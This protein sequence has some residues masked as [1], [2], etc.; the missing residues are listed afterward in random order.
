ME[1]T[2]YVVARAPG[3]ARTALL[4]SQGTTVG[5]LSLSRRAGGPAPPGTEAPRVL[6]ARTSEG[7]RDKNET[8]TAVGTVSAQPQAPTAGTPVLASWAEVLTPTGA[9]S[10]SRETKG[11]TTATATP[12]RQA[13]ATSR[14]APSRSP[15]TQT[16]PRL[17]AANFKAEPKWDFEE[18][19]SLDVGGL[20]TVSFATTPALCLRSDLTLLLALSPSPSLTSQA[21]LI[22]SAWSHPRGCAILPS[23]TTAKA[24]RRQPQNPGWEAREGVRKAPD[25]QCV[26]CVCNAN[27]AAGFQVQG[28]DPEG[29]HSGDQVQPALGFDPQSPT[30]GG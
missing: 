12:T 16:T 25:N 4:R 9:G 14:A 10:P 19:Y 2:G 17:R 28:A 23:C 22:G 15:V 3:T 8:P 26:V 13:Q 30:S 21:P 27:A 24:G 18:Q 5:T 11:V 6:D 7:R 1:A 20:Q 29:C